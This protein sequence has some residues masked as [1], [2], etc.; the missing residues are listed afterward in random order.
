MSSSF[1]EEQKTFSQVQVIPV[2][3][4]LEK[5]PFKVVTFKGLEGVSFQKQ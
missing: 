1:Q 3:C 2:T 5:R 4:T